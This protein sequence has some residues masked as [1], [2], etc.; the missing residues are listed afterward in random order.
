MQHREELETKYDTIFYFAFTATT[1]KCD[2]IKLS[3]SL[4]L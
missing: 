4:P 1:G 2:V 3:L